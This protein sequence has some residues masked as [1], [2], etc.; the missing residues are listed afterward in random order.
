MMYHNDA[1]FLYPARVTWSLHDIRGA[2][3]RQLVNLVVSQPENSDLMLAFCLMMIRLDGCLTCISDSYRAM[4]GC[5]VCARQTV[6]RFKG[7][8]HDLL[9]A[10]ESARLD[11]IGWRET[12]HMPFSERFPSKVQ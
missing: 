11:I 5:T 10:F 2:E 8:D 3:W 6:A 12:G 9:V 4:R 7:T 1:E